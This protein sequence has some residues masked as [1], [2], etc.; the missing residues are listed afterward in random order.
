MY[1]EDT[2]KLYWLFNFTGNWVP[3]SPALFK[4]QQY[5]QVANL[6]TSNQFWAPYLFPWSLIFLSKFIYVTPS[7][8]C[9]IPSLLL[10]ECIKLA[11]VQTSLGKKA[12]LLVRHCTPPVYRLFPL[13]SI[14]YFP[15]NTKLITKLFY[16][17]HLTKMNINR[18]KQN[19]CK[20][21][22]IRNSNCKDEVQLHI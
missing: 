20:S 13:E 2:Y 8:S 10:L 4:C 6:Q 7:Q 19:L 14:Y 11:L 9:S 18:F 17:C 5:I 15:L 12:P 1:T 3:V 21:L 22:H 16:F